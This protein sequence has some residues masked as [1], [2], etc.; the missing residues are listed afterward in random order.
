MALLAAVDTEG[1]IS[2]ISLEMASPAALKALPTAKQGRAV[3][4]LALPLGLRSRRRSS[5][6]LLRLRLALLATRAAGTISAHSTRPL[7]RALALAWAAVLSG[8]RLLLPLLLLEPPRGRR[9]PV[10]PLLRLLEAL[11]PMTTLVALGALVPVLLVPATTI[12]L[13]APIMT[14][15]SSP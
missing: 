10:V 14:P 5:P 12:I 2:A 3:P 11:L 1:I 9:P 15:P 6:L 7:A 4:G 8:S 13:K